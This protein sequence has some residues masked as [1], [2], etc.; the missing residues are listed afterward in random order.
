MASWTSPTI[1]ATGDILDVASANAWS[2]NETFLYQAP[3]AGYY[4]TSTTSLTSGTLTQITLSGTSFSNYG[5][6]LSSNNAVVPLTGIYSCN[7]AGQ[8]L[9]G[10]GSG[11]DFMQTIGF[12]NGTDTIN[13]SYIPSYTTSPASTASGLVSVSAGSTLSLRIIQ[14]SGSTLTTLTGAAQTYL[15]AFFVGSQ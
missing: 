6:S 4:N 3:Y 15:H 8:I 13:G 2:Y 10:A 5:F 9:S 11:G 12:A 7:F 14:T 1:F